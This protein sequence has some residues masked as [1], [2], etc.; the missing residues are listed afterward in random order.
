MKVKWRPLGLYSKIFLFSIDFTV[1]LQLDV[2][3]KQ[4]V[5]IPIQVAVRL[6]AVPPLAAPGALLQ[7]SHLLVRCAGVAWRV[8][9]ALG[10]LNP[11]LG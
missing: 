8:V 3:A 7:S 10:L 5:P 11:S 4:L 2:L 1:Y 9:A 6:A